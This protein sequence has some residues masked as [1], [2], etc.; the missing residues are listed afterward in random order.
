[1]NKI[2][3]AGAGGPASEG[4]IKSLLQSSSKFEIIGIG[5]ELSDLAVSDAPKKY[6]IPEASDVN[7]LSELE[8]IIN[9]EK[10][11]FIHAQNDRE[12]LEIS[13]YRNQIHKLGVKTFLPEHSV[14]STCINKWETYLAF[15]KN[16]IKV[17]KNIFINNEDDLRN[18]FETIA[19]EG[20]IWLRSNSIGGGGIGSL[21]TDDFVFAK[22]WIDTHNGWGNFLAAE[23]L[24]KETVT[25]LSIWYEG[26][27]VVAQSRK[28]G[29]WVH[30]NR[31]LSGI[32]GVT[33]IGQTTSNNLVNEVAIKSIKAVTDTPNG[34]FGVDMAYDDT[35]IPNPTEINIARFFTTILFFTSCGLNM[36]EIYVNIGL[37]KRNDYGVNVI[38]PL[39]EGLLWFRGM[40]HEPI[41]LDENKLLNLIEKI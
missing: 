28:R 41:L 16:K 40:D 9:K 34:I 39:P 1:M 37:T 22:K 4:V 13:K 25:W 21:P 27:L 32:T 23:I 12:V 3:V 5:S 10:P 31:T 15:E 33:K 38:N 30:G 35:G 7:Y 14:V 29:G 2:L 36:P 8:K 6:L 24:N 26:N 11:N 17:P 20:K 19:K 18:A